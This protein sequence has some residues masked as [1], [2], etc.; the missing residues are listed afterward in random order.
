[1]HEKRLFQ[2]YGLANQGAHAL[3]M[4]PAEDELDL[5]FWLSVTPQTS[6][7]MRALVSAM[8]ELVDNSAYSLVRDSA[9]RF[10]DATTRNLDVLEL[11]HR[12]LTPLDMKLS[13]HFNTLVGRKEGMRVL[14]PKTIS[15]G[16][17]ELS[18]IIDDSART[19]PTPLRY[20][21]YLEFARQP[22]DEEVK[23]ELFTNG[24]KLYDHQLDLEQKLIELE[25]AIELLT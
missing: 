25:L 8:Q 9:T 18:Q 6:V 12:N 23:Y 7:R 2:F 13:D 17:S 3:A 24:V 20:S 21:S 11:M 10:I 16:C 15:R 22:M 5:E 19:L 1:M 4:I 14:S